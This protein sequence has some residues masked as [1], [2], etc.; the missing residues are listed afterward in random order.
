LR[1]QAKVGLG[2]VECMEVPATATTASTAT[3]AAA[4]AASS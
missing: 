1:Q 4:G 2:L 3:S